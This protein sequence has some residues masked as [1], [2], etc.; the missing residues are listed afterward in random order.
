M[1]LDDRLLAVSQGCCPASADRLHF[2]EGDLYRYRSLFA[3]PAYSSHT[4]HSTHPTPTILL[5][6]VA[7]A[8]KN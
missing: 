7:P 6:P 1:T 5:L 4:L 8:C 2:V 3:L